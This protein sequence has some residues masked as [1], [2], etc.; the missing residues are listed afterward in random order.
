MFSLMYY[1][2]TDEFFF[3]LFIRA[4]SYNAVNYQRTLDRVFRHA[5][6]VIVVVFVVELANDLVFGFYGVGVPFFI[7]VG[8]YILILGIGALV[9]SFLFLIYSHKLYRRLKALSHIQK[10]QQKNMDRV[11]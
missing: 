3:L 5:W 8:I 6:I 1:N 7:V 11:L 4:N 10:L 2:Q 9:I